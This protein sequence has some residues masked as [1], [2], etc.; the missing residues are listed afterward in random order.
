M[1]EDNELSGNRSSQQSACDQVI[2]S[3]VD[4]K[5]RIER[6]LGTGG[7]GLV[8]LATDTAI[9]RQVAIK[10]LSDPQGVNSKSAQRF[11]QEAA[12]MKLLS[13]PNIVRLNAI[14]VH[15]ERS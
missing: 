13:H 2:G 8:Y 4:G 5:Y 15:E 9:G 6:H 7:M 10:F 3:L 11:K 1:L 12:S 14:G